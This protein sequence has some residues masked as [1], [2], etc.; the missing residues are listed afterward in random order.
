MPRNDSLAATEALL[1]EKKSCPA[2]LVIRNRWK[3]WEEKFR[4]A[5]LPEYDPEEGGNVWVAMLLHYISITYKLIAACIPPAE[6]KKGYPCFITA[7]AVLG[8]LMA[9]VK[10][11]RWGAVVACEVRRGDE[12]QLGDGK[13]TPVSS[14]R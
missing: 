13:A 6:W 10:E 1:A 2:P 7:L 4:E 14:L 9:I 5:V 3:A 8:G 12:G 11:V